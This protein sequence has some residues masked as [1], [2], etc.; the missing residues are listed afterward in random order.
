MKLFIP[1]SDIVNFVKKKAGV[2]I[3]IRFV[4]TQTVSISCR[5]NDFIGDIVVN[6]KVEAVTVSTF[7]IEL[8]SKTPGVEQIICGAVEFLGSRVSALK[9]LKV[10]GKSVE[11]ALKQITQLADV[12]GMVRALL[13]ETQADGFMFEITL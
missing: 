7:N 4:E 11:V 13:F 5:P 8:S 12:V 10:E 6:A 3:A 1:Y 9:F 2:D